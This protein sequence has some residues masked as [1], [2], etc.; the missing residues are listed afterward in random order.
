[1][2]SETTPY[3]TATTSSVVQHSKRTKFWRKSFI[4]Q[5]LILM[6]IPIP[7]FETYISVT[8]SRNDNIYP[9]IETQPCGCEVDGMNGKFCNYIKNVTLPT[10]PG[11]CL[12]CSTYNSKETCRSDINLNRKAQADCVLRC[13]ENPERIEKPWIVAT[14]LSDY[15]F[16]FMFCRFFFLMRT[17]FNH[18]IYT[19]AFFKKLCREY[20][21]NPGVRFTLK[22]YLA[23]NPGE[24]IS[25]LF[26][27]TLL[28]IA[29]VF[30]IFESP[31]LNDWNGN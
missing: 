14:F 9:I 23:T 5:M 22:C 1:M 19:D 3:K 10:K 11:T 17:I 26:I 25:I 12:S 8:A 24:T 7:E 15:F 4:F 16:A 29:Y 27:S 21:F 6:I 13:F 2:I 28:M 30:R 18:S 20:G 31:F